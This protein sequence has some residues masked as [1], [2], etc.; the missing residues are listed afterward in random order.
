MPGLLP[1]SH[2]KKAY[3]SALDVPTKQITMA[4]GK[5]NERLD[6]QTIVLN[7]PTRPA[8]SSPKVVLG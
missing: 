1:P 6:I 8:S 3:E 2:S 5:S 7:L 4:R